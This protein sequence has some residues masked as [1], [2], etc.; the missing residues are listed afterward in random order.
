MK[1]FFTKD[2]VLLQ[3]GSSKYTKSPLGPPSKSYAEL[4]EEKRQYGRSC[5]GEVSPGI[6]R[7][8]ET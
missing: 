3:W 5:T 6:E 8:R 4:R 7:E 1:T 2:E